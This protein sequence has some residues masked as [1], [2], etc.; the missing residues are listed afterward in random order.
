[1][2]IL[3]GAHCTF[4]P[5]GAARPHPGLVYAL[6]VFRLLL[7]ALASVCQRSL[8]HCGV[9]LISFLPDVWWRITDSNR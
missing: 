5:D 4:S 9:E 2:S 8:R 6:K 7:S 1:M 3:L